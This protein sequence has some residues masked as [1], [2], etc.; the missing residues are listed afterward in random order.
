MV[1]SCNALLGRLAGR[2][3]SVENTVKPK[4]KENKDAAARLALDHLLESV[5][6]TC[7]WLL[8]SRCLHAVGPN[9]QLLT[10]RAIIQ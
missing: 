8:A 10:A 1:H 4:E 3:E 6:A 5:I 7:K 2:S 9:S